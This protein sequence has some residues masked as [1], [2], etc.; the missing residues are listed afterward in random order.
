[1]MQYAI[2]THASRQAVGTREFIKV[3]NLGEDKSLVMEPL[4]TSPVLHATLHHRPCRSVQFHIFLSVAPCAPCAQR[5][6]V[7]DRLR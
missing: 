4:P 6:A 1:M 3:R 7:V 2:G 5:S